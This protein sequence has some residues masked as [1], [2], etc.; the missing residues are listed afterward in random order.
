[1]R[2]SACTPAR[3]SSGEKSSVKSAFDSASAVTPRPV[4]EMGTGRPAPLTD[5]FIVIRAVPAS[6]VVWALRRR[7]WGSR[8]PRRSRR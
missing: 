1:V 3:R 6:R 5:T 2:P 4:T 8:R 7:R